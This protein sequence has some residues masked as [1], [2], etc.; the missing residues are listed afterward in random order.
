[1]K[2]AF[3]APRA[4]WRLAR[5]APHVLVAAAVMLLVYRWR[6]RSWRLAHRQRW[7]RRALA[8]LGVGLEVRGSVV[9]TMRV[10]NHVSWLDIFALNAVSPAAFVAKDDVRGWPLV[11]WMS[12]RC[13]T[14]YLSRGSHRAAHQAS[15][16]LAEHLARGV[17]VVAFPEGT[18]SDGHQVLRF[19]AAL[20]EGAVLAGTAIQPIALHYSRLDQAPAQAPVYCGSTSLWQSLWRIA[21]ADFLTVH[22]EF[23]PPRE[24]HATERRELATRLRGDILAVMP[25]THLPPDVAA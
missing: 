18:T 19:H 12:E 15:R 24:T 20:L 21:S 10:A 8:I 11:G 1:M 13:E 3:S 25:W 4:I 17:D 7:S 14:I 23:L 16:D 5:L 2:D 9:A 6:P 22:L